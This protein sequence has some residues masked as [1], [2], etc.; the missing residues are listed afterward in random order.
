MTE[1]VSIYE[2][3][4]DSKGK[5]CGLAGIMEAIKTGR[6]KDKVEK[7]RAT[8]DE[9]ERSKL[10]QQIPALTPS[11]LFSERKES[12]LISHSNRL[13]VDFDLKDNAALQEGLQAVKEALC[14]DKYSE[15]VALSVSGK[16]LFVICRID[17]SRH[18][19]SF[20]FLES[21]YKET[22][23]LTIDKSCKDVS[24]LRFI[25]YDPELFHNPNAETVNVPE[26]KPEHKPEHGTHQDTG[27]DNKAV[28]D[29]IVKSGRVIG[30]DSY[31]DWLKI[32]LALA[33]AFGESGRQYFH[34]LSSRSGKY[35]AGDC[36]K[37]F[38][39]CL[40]S[41]QGRVGFGTIV[42]MAKA[43]GID[44]P[45]RGI[46]NDEYDEKN[47]SL[48]S[49]YRKPSKIK[50]NDENDEND[51]FFQSEILQCALPVRPFPIDIF[52]EQFKATIEIVSDALSIDM[53]VSTSIALS[54]F[55][56]AIGNTVRVSPKDGWEVPLFL[57]SIIIADSGLGKTPAMKVFLKPTEK[58]QAKAYV[59][60]Q[61]DAKEYQRK[62]GAYKK[63]KNIEEI[64]EKPILEQFKSSDFT[65]EGLAD[66]FE[67]QPRG[68]I[69][70]QDELAGFILSLNQYKGGKGA[71]RQHILELFNCDPWKIDRK[72]GSRYIPN[73]GAAVLG[74]IQPQVIP[75]IFDNESFVD[76]LLPRF[77]FTHAS[78]KMQRFN[79]K[80]IGDNDLAYWY[81]LVEWCYNLPLKQ[82][83]DGYVIPKILI[84]NE[85]SLD[86][87]ESFYN[88]FQE[89]A[90]YLPSKARVF[91]PK[92]ITY[93]L[94]LAGVLHILNS[95]ECRN[96]GSL[97]FEDIIE[98][99][100]KLTGYYAGQAMALV[101]GYGKPTEEKTEYKNRL[102][103]ALQQ[104][105][106][107]VNNGEL[108]YSKISEELNKTLPEQLKIRG[109]K[110]I[111]TLLRGL[112]LKTKKTAPGACL[113]WEG[114]KLEKLFLEN[115]SFSSI[116]H[117][118]SKIKASSY[119]E[120][121]DEKNSSYSS[122]A[123]STQEPKNE[124]ENTNN[125][126]NVPD[127]EASEKQSSENAS[128]SELS[129]AE[130]I[131]TGVIDLSD[132]ELIEE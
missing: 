3:S 58:L 125:A 114:E 46:T 112:G 82:N 122:Q 126:M 127:K 64:P 77:L 98:G 38:D 131:S 113:V 95:F 92:L 80:G 68:V 35:D 19:E 23:G 88:Q 72:S 30:D 40:R 86:I 75:S 97:I 37:K 53:E 123:F 73:T 34:D 62:L 100:T 31:G 106:C 24:R 10:K 44:I 8:V 55:S 15:Y 22:Y 45:H 12:G 128:K 90:A 50:A 85:K 36:D 14:Q 102:I 105:K 60:Y 61:E 104:L 41:N 49:S 57:W 117:F 20:V 79:R 65:I 7:V 69:L 87:W 1:T 129:D 76:G 132:F 18:A 94:K 29:A 118:P 16:G 48:D 4:F 93:S 66:V 52:P 25:S 81:D 63:D 33:S 74:G 71:D 84:L 107:E 6:W 2:N 43:I 17:G 115:S 110:T 83:S 89:I 119:D 91:V 67:C 120:S 111:G 13:A 28:M 47:S 116:R 21:Y 54:V 130:K 39:N 27:Y 99:A 124:S 9:K 101:S 121:Y 56:G 108:L 78:N 103:Y 11:G 26:S 42:H 5:T 32:G 96:M 59:K 51:E 109:N 70:H